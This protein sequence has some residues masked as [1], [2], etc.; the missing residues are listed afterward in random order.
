MYYL[1]E[2]PCKSLFLPSHTE[3]NVLRTANLDIEIKCNTVYT[4]IEINPISLYC[5][6]YNTWKLQ[7]HS[8]IN[9]QQ[10][11]CYQRG[12]STNSEEYF[13]KLCHNKNL[14]CSKYGKKNQN[15][16]G[17]IYS[18]NMQPVTYAQSKQELQIIYKRIF[19]WK[20]T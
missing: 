8:P 1:L 17:N 9:L 4:C 12:H 10:K 13:D 7:G 11:S 16:G 20:R 3:I 18:T 14:I 15:V 5:Q 19:S 6:K 2:C